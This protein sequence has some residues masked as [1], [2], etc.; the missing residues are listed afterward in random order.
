MFFNFYLALARFCGFYSLSSLL[1]YI[2]LTFLSR[3][4]KAYYCTVTTFYIL[5]N[6]YINLSYLGSSA[7][8]CYFLSS[9]YKAKNLFLNSSLAFGFD[10]SLYFINFNI[11]L[12]FGFLLWILISIILLIT[13]FLII[14]LHASIWWSLLR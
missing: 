7:F 5:S 1:F 4:S 11:S 8:S 14:F 10:K 2:I 6:V 3:L 13:I 12:S 9:S